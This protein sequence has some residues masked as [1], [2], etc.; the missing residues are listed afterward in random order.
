VHGRAVCR[1]VPRAR[2][3]FSAHRG[4]VSTRTLEVTGPL[5]PPAVWECYAV[6]ARWPEWAA[7]ISRVEI[8]APRLVAGATGKVHGPLGVTFPFVVD[9][10]DE[11]ARRWSWTVRLGLVKVR[12]EHWVTEGPDGGTT[13][14]MRAR[15]PG[16]VI[17]IYAAPARV[18]LDRLVRP[19]EE[20]R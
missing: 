5:D 10:V 20:R 12:L 8:S 14:G 2:I 16:P 3:A 15:G 4:R 6:P 17:A 9:A 1:P 13:T 19:P 7:Q 18:A 11:Q